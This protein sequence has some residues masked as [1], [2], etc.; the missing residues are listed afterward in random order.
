MGCAPPA[1]RRL[2]RPAPRPPRPIAAVSS[3]LPT[4]RTATAFD[5][6]GTAGSGGPWSRV[7]G[8]AGPRAR[9]VLRKCRAGCGG[10][11]ATGARPGAW[12]GPLAACGSAVAGR[13]G[14][15][16]AARGA[17]RPDRDAHVAARMQRAHPDAGTLIMQ[18]HGSASAG[19]TGA[20]HGGGGQARRAGA[21]APR[22]RAA[23]VAA[24]VLL[25]CVGD[26]AGRRAALT[27][28]HRAP[29]EGVD[30]R[31]IHQLIAMAEAKPFIY[32]YD[33][34]SIFNEG[35]GRAVTQLAPIPLPA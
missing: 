21:M 16:K 19:A 15:L 6:V 35:A 24:A 29:A 7:S 5:D 26:A 14:R 1:F 25:V 20:A 17:R 32:I 27:A 9:G 13:A 2:R 34:P 31:H 33:L 4:H 12:R 30:V 10:R 28:A 11:A 18:G 3:P 8:A 23:A 22:L